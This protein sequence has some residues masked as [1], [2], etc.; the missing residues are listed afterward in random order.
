MSI[1]NLKIGLII[2]MTR[3]ISN[4]HPNIFTYQQYPIYDDNHESIT[5]YFEHVYDAIVAYKNNN[6]DK[7]VF[8]HC[9]MGASRSVS[10]VLYY[11]MRHNGLTYEQGIDFLKNKRH[12]INPSI[13]FSD[14]LKN[15]TFDK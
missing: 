10:V 9:Y 13:K 2:N 15:I 11:L 12:I 8:I 1:K 7:G 3:E 5:E 14:E 4:Y 6:P